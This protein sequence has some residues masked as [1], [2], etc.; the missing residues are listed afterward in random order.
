MLV[1]PAD[2]PRRSSRHGSRRWPRSEPAAAPGSSTS[3]P[4]TRPT[5][6]I[7]V[8][9]AAAG[10]RGRGPEARLLVD[11]GLWAR[12]TCSGSS[13]RCRPPAFGL[14]PRSS[15]SSRMRQ[16]RRRDRALLRAPPTPPTGSWPRSRPAG[17]LAGRRRT[18]AA[19]SANGSS[20]RATRR[21]LRHRRVRPE[22]RVAPPRR[23][24]SRDPARRPD[25]PRHRR[26]ARRLQSDIT[27]TLWVDGWRR[28]AVPP[29]GLPRRCSAWSARPR[30]PRPPRSG[31]ARAAATSTRSRARSSRRRLRGRVHP[32]ARPRDRARGS[33]GS[34]S[35]GRQRRAAGVG[36]AFS[37]EPGIYLEGRFGVRIEDI[38]VCGHDGPTS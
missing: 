8:V 17:W 36:H 22:R 31:P 23:G 32:P 5:I 16:G 12:S 13:G 15:A 33:R 25:R 3:S 28:R 30:P 29:S 4:G 27:R 26:H 9:A 34:V 1:L 19:R 6:P 37:I 18:S 38:V 14:R 11:P 24:R 7:L 2:G 21:P 20:P 35:R 10:S